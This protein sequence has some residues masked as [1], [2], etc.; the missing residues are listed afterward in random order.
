MPK[1][2]EMVEIHDF[3]TLGE[4]IL[5]FCPNSVKFCEVAQVWDGKILKL[6][7][8]YKLTQWWSS[9]RI[10]ERHPSLHVYNIYNEQ[11]CKCLESIAHL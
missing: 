2:V 5:R 4:D 6:R 7:L 1:N 9:S 8:I 10:L 3:S 11:W